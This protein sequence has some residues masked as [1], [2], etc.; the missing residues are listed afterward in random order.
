MSDT[1]F[2]ILP[3]QI[4]HKLFFAAIPPPD[5]AE[6]LA[7]VWREQGTGARLRA[8]RLHLTVYYAAALP[9]ASDAVTAALRSAGDS[10]RAAPF[11]LTFDRLTAFGGRADNRALV[12]LAPDGLGAAQALSDALRDGCIRA[13][14]RPPKGGHATIRP[15]V[16]LAY[17]HGF[18]ADR[19]IAA[20]VSWT[21]DR[22]VLIDSL[23]GQGRH[24]H[25]AEWVLAR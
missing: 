9:Q 15:H 17:G 19:P 5:V 21:I 20:P 7:E 2:P 11:T 13:G 4:R 12:A 23:Q 1:L 10:L 18:D 24:V 6:A 25:L 3:A 8:D 16:T 22:V 14:V